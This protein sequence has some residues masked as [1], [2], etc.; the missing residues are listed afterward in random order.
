[1]K[2]QYAK[3]IHFSLTGC[4]LRDVPNAREI[5][6]FTHHLHSEFRPTLWLQPNQVNMQLILGSAQAGIND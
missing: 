4:P 6:G 1:L 2:H 5:A 3:V